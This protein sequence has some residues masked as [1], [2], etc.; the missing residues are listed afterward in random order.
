MKAAASR[1]LTAGIAAV[2]M[3]AA[4]T[5]W[6]PAAGADGKQSRPKSLPKEVTQPFTDAESTAIENIV[7][8]Y[9]LE[10]PEIIREAVQI[11]QQREQQATANRQRSA[12][13]AHLDELHDPGPLPVL[14]NPNGDVTIVE[15]FDYR[16]GYCRGVAPDLMDAVEA[17][18]NV[19]LVL[20]EFPILGP[21][22]LFAARAAVAAAKQGA[23]ATFHRRLMMDVNEVTQ[24]SVMAL[25]KDMG[26]DV[27][28]LRADM[29]ASGID[30]ALRASYSLA[31]ALEISGTPA[32]VVGDTLVPGALQRDRL[33][34]L[35]AEARESSS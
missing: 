26:L 33:E 12:V 25:A 5:S 16:C 24:D 2:A 9:I 29:N 6:T 30:E 3:T 20:K 31:E 28:Q 13:Q 18:G 27:E 14:G 15:F 23:Y 4:V 7:R 1:A 19:R 22:S 32:F 35:I 8:S 17:D 10:N 21:E 34:K 11:L